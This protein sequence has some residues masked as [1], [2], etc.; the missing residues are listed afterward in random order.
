MNGRL[1]SDQPTIAVQVR[2]CCDREFE[3]L[4]IVSNYIWFEIQLFIGSQ[5]ILCIHSYMHQ[6][7]SF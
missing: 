3:Q 7:L 4:N 6:M 1:P 2:N 5:P